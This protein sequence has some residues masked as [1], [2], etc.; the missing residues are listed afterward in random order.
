[1]L[2]NL[3]LDDTAWSVTLGD[4]KVMGFHNSGGCERWEMRS[5][6]TGLT[7]FY[8]V[9]GRIDDTDVMPSCYPERPEWAPPP[10][11]MVNGLPVPDIALAGERTNSAYVADPTAV[12]WVM[13]Y[14]G[15]YA[16]MAAKR[17]LAY[18]RT[19]EGKE[20]ARLHAMALLGLKPQDE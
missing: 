16:T 6:A 1:M 20:A 10:V 14:D 13:E 2:S 17:G 19:E 7:A 11:K 12:N 9:C 4:C 15:V 3:K 18:P 5:L 8:R